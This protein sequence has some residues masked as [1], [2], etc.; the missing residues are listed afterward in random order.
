MNKKTLVR[1][2]VAIV[3]VGVLGFIALQLVPY[4]R[5]HT[6]PPMQAEPKWDTP[7]T[8]E[9]AKRAC[10]DC[11]SNETAW[12]WYSNI[13][14]VSWL[15]Q[16]DVDEGRTKMNFSEWNKP[17]GEA[18]SA[19]RNVQRGSM[20]PAKYVPLHPTANLSA[21]EKQALITGFNASLTQ[22]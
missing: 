17:Q 4:G 7:R 10:F 19:A 6:N 1:I 21:E 5:N 18:R 20:P 9:L 22:R 16:K 12:P 13:A 8:R 3:A 11:H 2:L 14:P 15:I